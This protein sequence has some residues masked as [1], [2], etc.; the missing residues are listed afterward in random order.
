MSSLTRIVPMALLGAA[1]QTP[2]SP[3][4]AAPLISEVLYDAVGADNG[5][6]F[7]ELYGTP[8]SS[9]S[10]LSLQGINGANGQVYVTLTLSGTFNANGVFV[11]ADNI[12]GSI[13]HVPNADLVLNFDL[14]NGPDSLLLK[15]GGSVIDAL[16]YGVFGAGTFFAGEGAPAPATPAGQSLAR[17]I[18]DRDTNNNAVDFI[19]LGTPTP[20]QVVLAP[21]P[22]SLWLLLSGLLG[23]ISF[24]R[25]R[26]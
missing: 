17:R 20:G 21:L 5:Y 1:L 26:D 15:S 7:V 23:I 16:A 18:A 8:G 19:V 24:V 12:S 22:G 9:L 2:F 4:G 3:A 6:C 11:V 10:G 25:R 13:S 14:Q